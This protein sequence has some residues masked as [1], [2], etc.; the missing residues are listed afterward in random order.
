MTDQEAKREASRRWS[1]KIPHSLFGAARRYKRSVRV[2][3]VRYKTQRGPG[4]FEE[5]GRGETW[6]EAFA[7]ATSKGNGGV[8]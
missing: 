2:G 8:K 1:P 3:V 7:D 6:E 5:Y 4:H